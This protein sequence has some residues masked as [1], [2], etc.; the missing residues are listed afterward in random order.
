[1]APNLPGSHSMPSPGGFSISGVNES[2]YG[3]FVS[4]SHQSQ[5]PPPQNLDHTSSYLSVPGSV[6]TYQQPAN[7][8]YNNAPPPST[9]SSSYTPHPEVGGQTH[10][11]FNDS[12]AP[13]YGSQHPPSLIGTGD[14]SQ[15]PS[16]GFVTENGGWHPPSAITTGDGSQYGPSSDIVTPPQGGWGWSP[17]SGNMYDQAF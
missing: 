11:L 10:Q 6:I 7:W 15:Y 3:S 14:G 17:A 4:H 12:I 9:I 8:G 5:I 1:M 16:S 13:G 2:L